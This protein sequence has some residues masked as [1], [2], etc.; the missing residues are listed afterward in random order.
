MA[1]ITF[2]QWMDNRPGHQYRKST[3]SKYVVALK[4]V[5]ERL[6]IHLEKPIFEITDIEEFDKVAKFIKAQPNYEEIN[7]KYGRGDLSAGLSAYS[8]YLID[9]YG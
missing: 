6:G 4:K 2:E 9:V 3:I 1:K 7:R 5:E 8:Q